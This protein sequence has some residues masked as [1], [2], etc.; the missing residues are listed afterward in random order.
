[1]LMENR[2]LVPCDW[3]FNG[4]FLPSGPSKAA[5]F[6]DS[7]F[8]STKFESL[9]A[10]S[11]AIP[12]QFKVIPMH[13]RVAG[14]ACVVVRVQFTPSNET[15][16]S[17]AK[18]NKSND[19]LSSAPPTS[20]HQLHL[21]LSVRHN[22]KVTKLKFV[23]RGMPLR[24]D[25][26]PKKLEVGPLQPCSDAAGIFFTISNP[27][28]FAVEFASADFD[29]QHHDEEEI[30]RKWDGLSGAIIGAQ[31]SD[32]EKAV[33]VLPPR[34][35]GGAFPLAPPPSSSDI[36]DIS[37]VVGG[38]G[39]DS[40]DTLSSTISAG[41]SV[42][43]FVSLPTVSTLASTQLGASNAAIEPTVNVCFLLHG[44]PMTGKSQVASLL[45]DK[46]NLPVL[47]LTQLVNERIGSGG[48]VGAF[49]APSIVPPASNTATAKNTTSNNFTRGHG[50][51]ALQN[52]L[53]PI[54]S[55]AAPDSSLSSETLTVERVVGWIQDQM[56]TF[57]HGFILDSVEE[58]MTCIPQA[59]L[60]WKSIF[61]ALG[62]GAR[63]PQ[64]GGGSPTHWRCTILNFQCGNLSVVSRERACIKKERRLAFER[65]ELLR[66]MSQQHYDAL[67]NDEKRLHD[68]GLG[69]VKRSI[70]ELQAAINRLPK[71]MSNNA[72]V[73][74]DEAKKGHSF[75]TTNR[76]SSSSLHQAISTSLSNIATSVAASS[77]STSLGTSNVPVAPTITIAPSPATTPSTHQKPKKKVAPTL[78][79]KRTGD[80]KG[81]AG[82]DPSVQFA[83]R[84]DEDAEDG[85]AGGILEWIR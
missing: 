83:R 50:P 25:F 69:L 21:P 9:Q 27:M 51:H 76:A 11:A 61:D 52:Q 79:L 16:E 41:V 24:L 58:S 6:S 60:V 73:T 81:G 20:L 55:P 72:H 62:E 18:N 36:R 33:A 23:G 31:E 66:S 56:R 49:I 1:M 70:K 63:S 64:T 30:L 19:L 77:T 78:V 84:L 40:S 22:P 32:G 43:G 75:Q 67:S 4:T 26:E 82:V 17:L 34:S 68:S 59:P 10:S 2:G 29:L 53:S 38:I 37:S 45:S 44:P 15:S 46:W 71:N 74:E 14:G 65:L 80:S 47:N 12:K 57:K 85:A 3:T 35:C 5:K 54:P 39:A 13:G 28:P 7:T 42:P 48:G 8:P